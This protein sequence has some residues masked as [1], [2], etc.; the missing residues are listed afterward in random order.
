[1]DTMDP[2]DKIWWTTRNFIISCCFV[3]FTSQITFE[4]LVTDKLITCLTRLFTTWADVIIQILT[5]RSDDDISGF[6]KALFVSNCVSN[7]K[8]CKQ[9]KYNYQKEIMSSICMSTSGLILLILSNMISLFFWR[10]GYCLSF[11]Y[12]M[13]SWDVF[14]HLFWWVCKL[15]IWRCIVLMIVLIVLFVNS[16]ILYKS[17]L[18]K[19]YSNDLLFLLL[20]P[21]EVLWASK[22]WWVCKL[23]I[24]RCIVYPFVS[25]VRTKGV[26]WASWVL[27]FDV[28]SIIL[29]FRKSLIW[30]HFT[31]SYI[32]FYV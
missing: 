4:W 15:R 27:F 28:M 16:H 10:K 9:L 31:P 2:I 32:I 11:V 21:K 14:H 17:I 20:F 30:C 22:M 29:Q 23:E 12:T 6:H 26:L 7:S 5:E 8:P 3:F 18:Y 24:W 13:M 19:A 25:I 1:M